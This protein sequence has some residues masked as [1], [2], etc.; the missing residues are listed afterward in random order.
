MAE[1]WFTVSVKIYHKD[2][3]VTYDTWTGKAENKE[4]A[5]VMASHEVASS[6]KDVVRTE[7]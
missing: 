3:Q 5:K 2:G 7:A 6:H 1:H 4:D